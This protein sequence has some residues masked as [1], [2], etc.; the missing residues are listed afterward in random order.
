MSN[1]AQ[2]F[3]RLA[4]QFEGTAHNLTLCQNPK[5]RRELLMGMMV[6]LNQ[7]EDILR[8]DDSSLDSKPV[9]TS[10]SYPPLGKA[11]HQ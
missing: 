5:Q 8:N 3:G 11:A 6:V 2:R 7:I 4:A 10:P 9:S 1:A